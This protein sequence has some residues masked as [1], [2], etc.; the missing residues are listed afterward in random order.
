MV[1][2]TESWFDGYVPIWRLSLTV[3]RKYTETC[4]ITTVGRT[5]RTA[6]RPTLLLDFDATVYQ[7][8][9]G[10]VFALLALD[11]GNYVNPSDPELEVSATREM[12]VDYILGK[13]LEDGGFALSGDRGDPD[14]T[15]MALMALAN[16]REREDVPA[17]IERAVQCLSA[18]Q[19]S[20]GGFASWGVRNSQ[21]CAQVILA[22]SALG[23][24]INDG[25]FVKSGNTV[26]DCLLGYRNPDGG[27]ANTAGGE[28]SVISTEQA[29]MALTALAQK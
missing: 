12:Y 29:L 23:I 10:A 24:D 6:A 28:S 17:A 19:N 18:M 25:R 16:Y 13:Q 22:L 9:N 7:G 3:L 20:D 27:F 15:A 4:Q 1:S 11:S 21:S 2:R 5:R 26:L 8:V 14:M